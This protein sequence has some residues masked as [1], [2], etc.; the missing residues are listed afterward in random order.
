MFYPGDKGVAQ[1][2]TKRIL[3]AISVLLVCA[4]FAVYG[5]GKRE[6]NGDVV[7]RERTVGEFTG[8]TLDGVAKVNIHFAAACRVVVTARANIQ[9]MVTTVAEGNLLNIDLNGEVKN[10]DITVD[11]YLP[12]IDTINLNGVG[13]I[14][15]DEGSGPDLEIRCSGVGTIDLEKYRAGNVTVTGSGVGT[16]RIWAENSLNGDWSGIGSLYYKGNPRMQI[17]FNGVGRFRQIKQ[18][19][20]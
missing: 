18:A 5:R 15:S 20:R 14:E 4:C 11:V 6:G 7:S 12:A 16:I 9:D 3:A 13:S 10:S 19:A 17:N 8:L 2:K 1:M